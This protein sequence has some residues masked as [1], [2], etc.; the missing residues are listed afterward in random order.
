[1]YF[2]D[3]ILMV[4]FGYHSTKRLLG[5]LTAGILM[6]SFILYSQS[7]S[8]N[9]SKL[10]T[11]GFSSNPTFT[12][13]SFLPGVWLFET[14]EKKESLKKYYKNKDN[15]GDWLLINETRDALVFQKDKKEMKLL[16]SNENVS[17][18]L[19]ID[20]KSILERLNEARL[21]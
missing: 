16:F 13:A 7:D 3:L 10:E 17:F 4:V 20:G 14:K 15:Y 2:F 5:A 9:K 6:V 18:F 8:V 11:A 1:M 21:K 12:K 19:T